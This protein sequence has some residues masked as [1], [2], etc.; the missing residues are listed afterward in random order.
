[1]GI[2][3]A[4]ALSLAPADPLA[5]DLP[6]FVGHD[7]AAANAEFAWR[8]LCWVRDQRRGRSEWDCERYG[9]DGWEAEALDCW[10]AW[11]ALADATGAYEGDTGYGY[12]DNRDYRRRRLNDL[13]E[14]LGAAAYARGDCGPVVPIGRFREVP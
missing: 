3:L 4:L 7:G 11:D 9:L 2:T 5:E 6:R 14:Q 13:R 1:V 10:R 8:H 12:Y